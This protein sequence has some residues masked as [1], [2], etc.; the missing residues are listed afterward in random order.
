MRR[1]GI[2]ILAVAGAAGLGQIPAAA[3]PSATTAWLHVRVEETRGSKVNVNLPLPV[4]EA[5]LKAAPDSIISD[6]KIHLGLKNKSLKITDLRKMWLELKKSGDV[7]LVTVEDADEHVNVAKKGELLLV[8]VKKGGKDQVQVEIPAEVVDALFDAEGDNLNVRAALLKL[9]A[10][11]GDIVR[12]ND[13]DNTVR[14][15]IDEK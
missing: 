4:V 12:V 13:N 11:R 5:A 6:D 14:V 10:R 15:W 3:Q 7:D 1:L 8:H 9:Q 2:G